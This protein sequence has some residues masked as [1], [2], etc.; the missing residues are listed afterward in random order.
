[1]NGRPIGLLDAHPVKAKFRKT[2]Q[3][4]KAPWRLES[5][6]YEKGT[7]ERGENPKRGS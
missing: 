1:M 4:R 3:Q 7:R 6:A 5:R 2:L